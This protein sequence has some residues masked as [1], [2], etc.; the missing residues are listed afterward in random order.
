MLKKNGSF[1]GG[2]EY[3][4]SGIEVVYNGKVLVEEKQLT[5]GDTFG[6][7]TNNSISIIANYTYKFKPSYRV[8]EILLNSPAY[9]A[10]VR[11]GDVLY[12]ING[13]EVYNYKLQ[14][15]VEIFQ[16]KP[17]MK[18]KL[19]VIR[20]NQILIVEFRLEKLI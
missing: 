12:K 16:K 11:R 3:N 17:Q 4:M 19:V 7:D 18:I 13:K 14:D 1:K 2:F 10:G 8:Q 6:K 15:I 5:P 20:N 9:K